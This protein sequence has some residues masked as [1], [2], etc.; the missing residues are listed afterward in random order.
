MFGEL[1]PAL[2]FEASHAATNGVLV[3]LFAFTDKDWN[4]LR[5]DRQLPNGR[6]A[7]SAAVREGLADFAFKAC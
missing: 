6:N 7:L 1:F 3:F 4:D 2:A 5:T